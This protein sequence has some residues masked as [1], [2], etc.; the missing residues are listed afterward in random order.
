MEIRGSAHA[1][2]SLIYHVILTVKY[3]KHLLVDMEISTSVKEKIKEIALREGYPLK[4]I[5]VD[6][7]HIHFLIETTPRLSPSQLIKKIKQE[8][9]YELW[10]KYPTKLQNQFWKTKLFWSPSYFITSV[11]ETNEEIITR[12]INNQ[13]KNIKPSRPY[14]RT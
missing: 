7:D 10:D 5:E 6:K 4:S 12:Y 9:T 8:T 14:P 3:R 1:R 2:Y 11:G 13:G